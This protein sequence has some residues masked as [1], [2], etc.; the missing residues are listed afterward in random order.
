[1][2][3]LRKRGDKWYVEVTKNGKRTGKTFAT[4]AEATI[5]AAQADK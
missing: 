3:A 5:W 4:K 1:M 2:A